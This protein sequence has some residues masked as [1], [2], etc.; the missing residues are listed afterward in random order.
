MIVATN[1]FCIMWVFYCLAL[2]A[3]AINREDV[4]Q[5]YKTCLVIAV[6]VFAMASG[7]IESI[8]QPQS[9]SLF[10]PTE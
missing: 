9:H 1:M 8:S 7:D 10:S 6:F 3:F 2:G 4:G 5:T